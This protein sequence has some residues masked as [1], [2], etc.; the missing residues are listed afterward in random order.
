MRPSVLIA[1][2]TVLKHNTAWCNLNVRK[3]FSV[4]KLWNEK[5]TF[6]FIFISFYYQR[7]FVSSTI[8]ISVGLTTEFLPVN[9]NFRPL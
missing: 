2:F 5:I 3:E 4:Y 7:L 6:Y 1:Y 8:V 9:F